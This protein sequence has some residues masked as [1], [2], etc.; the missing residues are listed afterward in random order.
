MHHLLTANR[1]ATLAA[2]LGLA[3][4]LAA[5]PAWAAPTRL[6]SWWGDYVRSDGDGMSDPIPANKIG[7][8]EIGDRTFR[9]RNWDQRIQN[10]DLD[11]DSDITDDQILVYTFSMTNP[12]NP[13]GRDNT[14]NRTDWG[15]HTN[16]PSAKFYGGII[17]RFGNYKAQWYDAGSG[18]T[19][20][21]GFDQSTVEGHEGANPELGYYPQ[22][23]HGVY[24]GDINPNEP[25]TAYSDLTLFAYNSD[26]TVPYS[27]RKFPA[28]DTNPSDDLANFNAMFMWKKE[29]FLGGGNS[30]AKVIIDADSRLSIDITRYFQGI[31]N[32]RWVIQD[33]ANFYISLEE[34]NR[35]NNSGN[36]LQFGKTNE[37]APDAAMWALINPFAVNNPT[38]WD[39]L[40]FDLDNLVYTHRTFGDVQAV[41][42]YL[43]KDTFSRELSVFAADY[44]TFDATVVP[45]PEPMTLG[46]MGLGLA[47]LALRRQR[48]TR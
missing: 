9:G 41:G 21:L 3:T 2:A 8:T 28:L 31:E 5:G 42:F 11:G 40:N 36:D 22:Y 35:L 14:Q 1:Q 34:I 25:P 27:T 47:G 33:G 30:A 44:I 16:Q 17:G 4:L 20:A 12:L 13:I 7:Q 38:S 48:K 10:I 37:L 15:Y 6:V 32:A 46:L 43:E 18:K 24:R 23:P 19:F 26:M 45:V 29:D 39:Y